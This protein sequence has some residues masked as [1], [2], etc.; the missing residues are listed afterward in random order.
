MPPRDNGLYWDGD[1]VQRTIEEA[2]ELDDPHQRALAARVARDW[3][4]FQVLSLAG[5]NVERE[6][7]HLHAQV[8]GLTAAARIQLVGAARKVWSDTMTTLF[9]AALR[10]AGA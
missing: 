3:A 8:M 10:A 9:N 5:Q 6:M 2:L 1:K 7:A 4:Q